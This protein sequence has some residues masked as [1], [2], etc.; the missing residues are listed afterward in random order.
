MAAGNIV[1]MM[2]GS[3]KDSNIRRRHLEGRCRRLVLWKMGCR[4]NVV[5]RWKIRPRAT[6]KGKRALS[7]H[8][9]ILKTPQCWNLW[10]EF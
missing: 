6:E 8:G 10:T 2:P 3:S 4:M 7:S 1:Q 9:E 5:G